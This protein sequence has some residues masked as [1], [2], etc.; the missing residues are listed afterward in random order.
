MFLMNIR[1][2]D[3]INML[4]QNKMDSEYTPVTFYEPVSVCFHYIHKP[5]TAFYKTSSQFSR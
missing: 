1:S 4:T 3:R 5:S 2:G